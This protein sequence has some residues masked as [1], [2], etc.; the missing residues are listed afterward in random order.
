MSIAKMQK[1]KLQNYKRGSN[2]S[3]LTSYKCNGWQNISKCEKTET[4]SRF[5]GIEQETVTAYRK[6]WSERVS[7]KEGDEMATHPE[8]QQLLIL[9]KLIFLKQTIQ[10]FTYQAL[11]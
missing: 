11:V 7:K 2:D 1:C 9:G 5:H 4:F 10:N 8:A 3:I 6:G